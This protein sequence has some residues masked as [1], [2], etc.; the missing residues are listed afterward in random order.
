M[1]EE[2]VKQ[3]KELEPKDSENS[4]HI[5]EMRIRERIPSVCLEKPLLER[6]GV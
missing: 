1:E 4:Q 3:E 5:Q 2:I 6:L